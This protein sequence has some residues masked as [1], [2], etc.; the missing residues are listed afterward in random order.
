MTDVFQHLQTARSDIDFMSFAS[1]GRHKA[2]C[3]PQCAFASR[4]AWHCVAEY[5]LARE[6]NH[7]HDAGTN[8]ERLG[9][10]QAT[11]DA[12]HYLTDPTRPQSFDKPLHLDFVDF[13]AALIAASGVAGY[14][15]KA[16]VGSL[17]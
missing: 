3:L 2:A 14:I 5:V 16:F 13:P 17:Q 10:V 15:G 8:D 4:E 6:P 1:Y 12:D 9:R 7:V 11:G